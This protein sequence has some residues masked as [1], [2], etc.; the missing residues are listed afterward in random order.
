MKLYSY[1]RSSAAYRVRIALN[2]KQVDYDLVSVNLVKGEQTAEPYT[3]MNPQGL[4]PLLETNDGNVISQSLA[5][6][7]WLEASYPDPAL[8][9]VEPYEAAR[10]RA[11]ALLIAC[12][13]HP[14]N[15]L[16]ILTYLEDD[17]KLT[18]EQKDGWYHHWVTKGFDALEKLIS[19]APY[20]IGDSAT[21]AD[22]F[23]IPQV[24]NAL[25]FDVDM[26]AYPGITSIYNAC[27][28]TQPFVDARPDNQPDNP[29]N[30]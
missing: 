26:S 27:N 25:R 21:L 22:A 11:C 16:R 24:F 9:P 13:I 29:D 18:P 23:L 1:Y 6:C 30:Q 12:E 7:E 19:G 8:I 4:V 28:E 3:E 20:C 17:M 10:V 15:N 5:I 14:L 2:L